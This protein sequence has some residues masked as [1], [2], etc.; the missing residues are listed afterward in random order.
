MTMRPR[1]IG[2]PFVNDDLAA[3]EERVGRLE[4][5]IQ[6]LRAEVDRLREKIDS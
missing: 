5:T 3:C 2:N 6:M 4:R 1:L